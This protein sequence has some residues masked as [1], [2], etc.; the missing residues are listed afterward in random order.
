MVTEINKNTVEFL[1]KLIKY[2]EA[3]DKVRDLTEEEQILN[4]EAFDL[5][6]VNTKFILNNH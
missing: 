4:R 5:I 3:I 2:F 1:L 6:F